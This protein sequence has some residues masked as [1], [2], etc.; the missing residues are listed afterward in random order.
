MVGVDKIGEIRRAYFDRSGRS[1]RSSD[2]FG[3]SGDGS[4]V[5]RGHQ[6]ESST[7]GTFSPTPKLGVWS[8]R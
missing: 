7:R 1:K 8:R 5:I 6:T 3:L 2:A 4:Q